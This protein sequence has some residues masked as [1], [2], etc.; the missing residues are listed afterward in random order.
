[1]L[2]FL[3]PILLCGLVAFYSLPISTAPAPCPQPPVVDM[4]GAVQTPG[5]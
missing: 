2:R 3:V 1:M 4:S 5:M